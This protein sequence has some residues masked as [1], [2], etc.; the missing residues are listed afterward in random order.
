MR[1]PNRKNT[2]KTNTVPTSA[3]GTMATTKKSPKQQPTNTAASSNSRNAT[4]AL[5]HRL[6][7]HHETG[8]APMYL[9][10]KEEDEPS[11]RRTLESR[12][13]ARRSR[14][15]KTSR[16]KTKMKSEMKSGNG[17]VISGACPQTIESA[18]TTRAHPSVTQQRV[19]MP[20]R[21]RTSAK[22]PAAERAG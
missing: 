14:R 22:D 9:D 15:R 20:K 6:T 13:A 21:H 1:T 11:R 12:P 8:S 19:Q 17:R 16:S 10:R 2:T 4:V 3:G 5:T 18:P 7:L